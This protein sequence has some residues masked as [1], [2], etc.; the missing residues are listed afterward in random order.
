MM[1]TTGGFISQAPVKD[2]NKKRY[3]QILWNLVQHRVSP[4]D[5]LTGN[6]LPDFVARYLLLGDVLTG[7]VWPCCQ[8]MCFQVNSCRVKCCDVMCCQVMCCQVVCI[9]KFCYEKLCLNG[10]TPQGFLE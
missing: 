3:I 8:V 9:A 2:G 5:L 10:N 7:D 6:F 4:G 1:L